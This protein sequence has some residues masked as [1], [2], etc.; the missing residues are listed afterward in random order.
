ME[1]TE[2]IVIDVESC[3]RVYLEALCE[4]IWASQ[5]LV[6]VSSF[7]LWTAKSSILQPVTV[8][9]P[10]RWCADLPQN[11]APRCAAHYR[12]AFKV[13]SLGT[14]EPF[15]TFDSAKQTTRYNEYDLILI[16]FW[17]DIWWS[18]GHSNCK[19]LLMLRRQRNRATPAT[20]QTQNHCSTVH[21]RHGKFLLQFLWIGWSMLKQQDPTSIRI[22]GRQ[23]EPQWTTANSWWDVLSSPFR[24]WQPSCWE[25]VWP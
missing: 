14:S 20:E 17:Y 22:K 21:E 6:S 16:W 10:T 13:R 7:K 24:P 1:A 5:H 23:S 8:S 25:Q 15:W 19:T 4:H 12:H 9:S 3:N 18:C 11:S 2:S